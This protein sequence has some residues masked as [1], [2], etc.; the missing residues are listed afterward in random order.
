MRLKTVLAIFVFSGP[1]L[2]QLPGEGSPDAVIGSPHDL[3]KSVNGNT[4]Q[5]CQYCHAKPMD[6]SGEALPQKPRAERNRSQSR[7]FRIFKANR[8]DAPGNSRQVAGQATLLCLRCHYRGAPPNDITDHV[9]CGTCHDAHNGKSKFFLLVD[10]NG[11]DFCLKCHS[12]FG[13]TPAKSLALGRTRTTMSD[14]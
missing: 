11:G 8:A 6:P 5:V 10:Y 1:L 3:R 9:E 4:E 7:G 13:A 2:A 12:D 14:K